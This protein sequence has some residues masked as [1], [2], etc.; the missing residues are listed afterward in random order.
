MRWGKFHANFILLIAAH[1]I[2]TYYMA[3]ISE[4]LIK[5]RRMTWK[6]YSTRG[7]AHTLESVGPD[8]ED[9]RARFPAD[10][11]CQMKQK[12]LHLK[13]KHVSKWV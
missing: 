12:L 6:I 5:K 1:E 9:L 3:I 13:L 11:V 10:G 4:S 8:I 7:Q 2:T